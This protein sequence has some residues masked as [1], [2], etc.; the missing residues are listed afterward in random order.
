MHACES[1]VI[2]FSIII[3]WRIKLAQTYWNKSQNSAKTEEIERLGTWASHGQIYVLV[4]KA[5]SQV[6]R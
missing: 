1:L 4:L 6:Q 5:G 2:L 3:S